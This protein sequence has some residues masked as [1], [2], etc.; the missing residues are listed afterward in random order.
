[1]NKKRK[2]ICYLWPLLGIALFVL[3]DQYTKYLAITHLKNQPAINIWD[4]VFCLQYLENKGAAFGI[5]QNQLIFFLISTIIILIGLTYIYIKI[6]DSPQFWAL[7]VCVLLICSGAIGNLIDRI[8][9]GYVVDFLYFELIDFPIFNV[10][11]I[12]VTVSTIALCVLLLF[13]YKDEDFDSIFK[14]KDIGN[15]NE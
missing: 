11:D 3:L 6:A 10:A 4:N 1:M 8:R 9:F 14:I 15:T 13:V 5:L 2:L 12:Y 7:R